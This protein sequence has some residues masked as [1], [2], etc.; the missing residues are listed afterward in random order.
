MST[1][2]RGMRDLD[3]RPPRRKRSGIGIVGC[4][5]VVA[6]WHLPAY[7]KYGLNVVGVYDWRAEM[8]QRVAARFDVGRIYHDLD[9]LLSDPDIIVVDVATQVENRLPVLLA[10]LQAGKHV[11]AQ[12]PVAL[13]VRD[14]RAVAAEAAR[15]GLVAAVN[16]NGRWAPPWKIATRLVEEGAVGDVFAVTHLHDKSFARIP[17]AYGGGTPYS[18]SI[19][20]YSIHWFDIMRCWFSDV[21][22]ES[23]RAREFPVPGQPDAAKR[24][25]GMWAEVAFAG[26][27]SGLIRGIGHS[28][29][30]APGHPFFIHGTGGVIRGSVLGNDFVELDTPSEVRRFELKGDWYPD[31]FA[32]AM[33][34]VLRSIE[35]GR[36]PFNSVLHNIRSLE[37][38]LA[39][40]ESAAADGAPVRF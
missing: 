36:E 7:A 19:Y 17:R 22:P 4:G 31:G 6:D 23:V 10:A 34:E 15:L 30:A 11:L 26:G 25:W 24:P 13:S 38:T 28:V 1:V 12:K 18:F 3:A 27:R 40:C 16:Q 32:S 20:E 21:P 33:C 35:E 14:A 39:A 5:G 9:Q 2:D 37:I 8:S 29:T